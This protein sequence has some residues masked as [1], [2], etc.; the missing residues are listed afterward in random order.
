MRFSI[1]IVLRK[2]F[3]T[4]KHATSKNQLTKTKTRKATIFSAQKLHKMEK[5]VYFAFFSI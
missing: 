1:S 5:I 3:A 4:Q 2:I